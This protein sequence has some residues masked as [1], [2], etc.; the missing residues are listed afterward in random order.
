MRA[1]A[2]RILAMC[3][4]VAL[5]MG[6]SGM[7]RSLWDAGAWLAEALIGGLIGIAAGR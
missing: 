2:W 6:V 5:V 4:A 1:S 3:L 7:A